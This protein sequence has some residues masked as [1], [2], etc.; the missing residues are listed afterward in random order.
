MIKP[1][2]FLDRDGVINKYPGDTRYV[3]SVKEFRFL[4]GVKKAIKRLNR[5]GALVF[6]ASNQA[7]VTKGVYSQSSLE[8]ITAHML[9]SLSKEGA[10][11]D[12]VYYCIH[13]ES[14]NCAC[15]KP[16]TG[17]IDAACKEFSISRSRLKSAFFVG[18][19]I[20]DVHTGKNAGLSTILVFSGK[21]KA[22]NSDSWELK[23]DFT[24]KG[25]AE[26]V[27][28]ILRCKRRV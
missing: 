19:T 22:A 5:S 1:I 20:R 12:R 16:K 21:E 4:P 14:F 27:D 11:L 2:V 18:D 23:P 10:V 24:A 25:L 3:T 8:R 26:A 13:G 17:M 28:I 15:R 6:V 7:G 9:A